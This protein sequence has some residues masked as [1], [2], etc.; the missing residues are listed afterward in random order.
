MVIQYWQKTN[1]PTPDALIEEGLQR[2]G[3]RENVGWRHQQLVALAHAHNCF[4]YAE[5]FTSVS[6]EMVE[7]VTTMIATGVPVIISVRHR[8]P[9]QGTHLL[10]LV[11]YEN[12]SS[13]TPSAWYLH[14]PEKEEGYYRLSWQDGQEYFRPLTLF[15]Y[16]RM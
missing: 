3:Y 14:D 13:Q 2:E 5:D 1:T 12:G 10:V 4:G 16:G 15:I 9:R 6:D 11:G 7:K 8:P